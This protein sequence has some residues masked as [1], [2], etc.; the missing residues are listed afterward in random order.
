MSVTRIL[1]TCLAGL[2]FFSAALTGLFISRLEVPLSH[3]W[4]AIFKQSLPGPKP[5]ARH[6]I[7]W[8]GLAIFMCA[9]V[10]SSMA[11]AFLQPDNIDKQNTDTPPPI[12]GSEKPPTNIK[13]T[14]FSPF[15]EEFIESDTFTQT[16]NSIYLDDAQAFCNVS[17]SG[18]DQFLYRQI[19]SIS[20]DLKFTVVGQVDGWTNNCQCQVG[21]GDKV[22]E[23]IGIGFGFFG[24][25]CSYQGALV[26]PIGQVAQPW[27]ADS[28]ED[29]ERWSWVEPRTPYR[30]AL[31][32]RGATVNFFIEGNE[33]EK[34]FTTTTYNQA[35][36][37]LWVG[38]KGDGD[39]P[40]CSATFSSVTIEPVK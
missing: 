31:E 3:L 24:G 29:M 39:W 26:T 40:E 10:L 14:N 34:Y 28:C 8:V 11:S 2:S 19:P 35:Y 25:G 16:T 4:A 17:R 23:G 12:N 22:G 20:G 1:L 18:G 32:V 27:F 5:T 15:V 38:L 21:I 37:V 33:M 30:V 6:Y 7:I 13:N 9:G 36:S